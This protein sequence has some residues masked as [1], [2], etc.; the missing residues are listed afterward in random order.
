[1]GA[2]PSK[3]NGS[4]MSANLDGSDVRPV[5]P[6]GQIHTPKQLK[7]DHDNKKL[8]ICDREGLRVHR[9]DFDGSNHEIIVQTGDANSAAGE[10][11]TKWC[12]GIAIDPQAGKFYWSQKGPSKGGKGR[13]ASLSLL[14]WSSSLKAK[15]CT[16]QIAANTRLVTR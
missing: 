4:V 1:M 11:Q 2:S 3:N 12:V 10:D 16:G 14:T 7:I 8:Y 5:I 13:I 15:H 9:C 6:E